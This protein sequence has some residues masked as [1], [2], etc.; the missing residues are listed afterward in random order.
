MNLHKITPQPDGTYSA[1]VE[2]EDGFSETIH[3]LY[4]FDSALRWT[5]MHNAFHCTTGRH[6]QRWM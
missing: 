1:S 3:G 6:F 4:D 5:H 2:M